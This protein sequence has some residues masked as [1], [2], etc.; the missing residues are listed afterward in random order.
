MC[1]RNYLRANKVYNFLRSAKKNVMR[2]RSSQ[3]F[4]QSTAQVNASTPVLYTEKT[5]KC[6]PSLLNHFDI[7]ECG[8]NPR[9]RCFDIS[10][11]VFNV[12]IEET[13]L[14]VFSEAS[15][16]GELRLSS[17]Q[18]TSDF[19][20]L[21]IDPSTISGLL[22]INGQEPCFT[23]YSG[24]ALQIQFDCAHRHHAWF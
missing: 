14:A 13:A 5:C 2:K 9:V 18:R 1:Q 24:D 11:G 8:N 3:W 6:R 19:F 12:T 21:I 4:G 16:Y 10:P 17:H 23:A 22:T 7:R 15:I 20:P